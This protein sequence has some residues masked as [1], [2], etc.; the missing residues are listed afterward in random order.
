MSLQQLWLVCV[1]NY[2][3][4]PDKTIQALGAVTSNDC[5]AV[6]KF[7]T[8]ALVVGTLDSLVGLSDE[9]V[10][11]NTQVENVVRKVERQYTEIAGSS[12]EVLRINEMTV[13]SYLRKFQWDFARYRHQG[14]QLPELV[15]QIHGMATKI[16]EEL[17]KLSVSYSEKTQILSALQRKKTINLV[18]SDLEDIL[19]PAKVSKLEFLNSD[20]LLSVLVVVPAALEQEFLN[21]YTSIGKEIAA[22]GGPDWQASKATIGTAGEKFGADANRAAKKG[23]PVVPGSAV[24]IHTENDTLLYSMVILKGHYEAGTLNGD[25]FVQGKQVDY[26]EPLRT[27][28]REKRFVLRDYNYDASKSGSLDTQLEVAKTELQQANTTVVRWCRAHYGEVYSG[29]VHLKVIRA[30]SEAVLRYGLPVDF[31]SVF[32]EPNLRREKQAK[33]LLTRTVSKLSPQ[34]AH[35]SIEDEDEEEDTDNLPYVCHKFNVIG[36]SLVA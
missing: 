19:P 32:I 14:R 24:K 1:P 18:T 28:F 11:L 33:A 16:D 4:S 26:V 20:T 13:E 5:G 8:P 27:A 34:M 21:T 6:H 36:A 9:L 15:S 3:A 35:L 25:E 17:K 10:K 22:Y 29:W 31:T 23:S 2:G 12:A 7:E 30:F